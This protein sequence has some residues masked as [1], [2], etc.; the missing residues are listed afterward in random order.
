MQK[1]EELEKMFDK[2]ITDD[3]LFAGNNTSI[4]ES[5]QG[6][7]T[8]DRLFLKLRG[9]DDDDVVCRVK[10]VKWN[11]VYQGWMLV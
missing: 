7:D 5:T 9:K 3:E 6:T 8:E 11:V 10:K 4:E 2:P 1:K